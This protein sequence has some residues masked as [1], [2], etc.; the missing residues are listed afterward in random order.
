[1][2]A[3]LIGLIAVFLLG[4]GL[5]NPLSAQDTVTIPKARLKELERKEAELEKLTGD[6]SKAKPQ[7]PQPQKQ[8][9]PDANKV[10]VAPHTAPAAVEPTPALNSLPPL[11]E[12]EVIDAG[13]FAKHYHADAKTAD[14]RYKNRK[15]IIHGEV[16]GFQKPMFRRDYKLILKTESRETM[17]VCDIFPPEKYSAVFTVK[18]GTEL[19][20]LMA[21]ETRVPLCKVGDM[22]EVVGKCKGLHSSAVSMI[23]C[24]FKPAR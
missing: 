10:P 4:T 13:D 12:G 7:T 3:K 21:R 2:N 5:T 18:N 20:G 15:L 14:Q 11:R 23:D 8:Q 24:E 19:V 9:E 22:V 6:Q 16:A 1:M 17:V